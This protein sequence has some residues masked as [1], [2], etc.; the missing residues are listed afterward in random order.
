MIADKLATAIAHRRDLVRTIRTL[1]DILRAR[2]LAIACGYEHADGLDYVRAGPA[3]KVACGR[4]PDT[5][6]DPRSEPTVPPWE[7]TPTLREIIRLGQV[8]V[9]RY[10]AS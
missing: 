2:I 4:L 9:D 3:F 7:N 6:A 1:S 5:E 10:C 8:I